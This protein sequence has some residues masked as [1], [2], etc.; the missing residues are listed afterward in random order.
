VKIQTFSIIAGSEA[1]N[2]RCPFCVSKMT[3]SCGF[4]ELKE[5]EVNWRNFEKACLLAKQSGATTAM[6]TGKGEPTLF[7]DQITS[8]L[9]ELQR[10]EFPLIEMQTNGIMLS[11]KPQKYDANLKDWY[12]LGMTTIAISIVHYDPTPNK[13]IYLANRSEYIDLPKLIEKLHNFGFSVRLT[14]IAAR[15][16]IDTSVKLLKLI[17]F[18]KLN[19][20]EQLTIT[21]VNKP[22]HPEHQEAWDWTNTHHLLPEQLDEIKE[23]LKTFGSEIMHLGHGAVVY[24]VAGQNVC[25]NNCLTVEPESEELR[26]IIFFPDGHVRTHWQYEGSILF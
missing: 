24:D 2:A 7:P 9:D 13:V 26:N 11:E 3:P 16:Y 21:P 17:Q 22:E 12:R 5:P 19:K 10:H 14:C 25:L 18:A 4:D 20:V 1:C 23:F 15:D 6:F 8:Y